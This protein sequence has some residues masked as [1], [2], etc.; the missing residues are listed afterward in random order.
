MFP[1]HAQREKTKVSAIVLSI[2]T[3]RKDQVK[4]DSF[5]YMHREK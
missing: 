5:L 1:L 3:E 2:F 4:C